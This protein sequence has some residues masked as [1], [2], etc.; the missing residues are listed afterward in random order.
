MSNYLVIGS[1]S[2]TSQ[3]FSK[4]MLAVAAFL[5]LVGCSNGQDK[6]AERTNSDANNTAETAE[7]KADATEGN[8]LRIGTEG[9]YA[10]FNY[11]NADGTLGGFDIEIANAI[12]AD[13][14][15][16]CE[17][18]AQDWDGIIPGL[19]AGKY[20]AIVAAMSVTPERAQ[21]VAFTD[22]YFSNALVFLAKK[23]ST[24]DPAKVTDINAHSIAAQRSTIS[25]QWL[26]NTYPKADMKL[27]D[28]LSNAFLDLGAGRVDA[29]ISDKLPAIE[30]LSSTSGNNYVLKGAEIDIN[31]NFAIAVRPNDEALQAKINTSLSN[32]KA[33]G[34]YD[35]INQKYFAVPASATLTEAPAIDSATQ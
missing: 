32:I 31:D 35:K 23:D 1:N 29:M 34:T 24:F 18:V 25:S 17:I 4:P 26:E 3:R 2:V 15:V 13:M 6:G 20:D 9:A 8:V 10:P 14:Q 16:T 5:A 33:N 28:T 7:K 11:T 12:C 21:Q 30:W 22:P 19:K 27:Y